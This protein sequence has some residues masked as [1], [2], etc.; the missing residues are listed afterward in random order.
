MA[1][2]VACRHVSGLWTRRFAADPAIVVLRKNTADETINKIPVEA[3]EKFEFV[4]KHS[5]VGIQIVDLDGRVTAANPASVTSAA[6]C[7]R[8][9][10]RTRFSA[11]SLAITRGEMPYNFRA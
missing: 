5:P 1:R 2:A 6:R 9:N 4:W 8:A 11:G 10:L 7:F 3:L